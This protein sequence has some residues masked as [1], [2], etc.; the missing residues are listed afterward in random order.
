MMCANFTAKAEPFW[1]FPSFQE[2]RLTMNTMEALFVLS[3]NLVPAG[4]KALSI[5]KKKKKSVA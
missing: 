3:E 5:L 1:W 4:W 2:H